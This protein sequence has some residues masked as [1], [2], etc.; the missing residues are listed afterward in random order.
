MKQ[1]V[2]RGNGLSGKK[3]EI[4]VTSRAAEDKVGWTR[5]SNSLEKRNRT[6]LNAL[7]IIISQD[8]KAGMS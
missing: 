2:L 4:T 8:P 5:R 3:Q 1:G 6:E 7:E